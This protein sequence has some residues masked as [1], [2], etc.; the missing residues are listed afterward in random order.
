MK[1]LCNGFDPPEGI[2]R[3]IE[4]G[5]EVRVVNKGPMHALLTFYKRGDP[6]SS[7]VLPV[8]WKT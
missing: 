6:S 1:I 5:G 3:A 2:H 8:H 7:S 4:K